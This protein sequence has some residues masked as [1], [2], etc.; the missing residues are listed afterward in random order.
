MV[1]AMAH[2]LGFF[3]K[4]IAFS[5][6]SR[7]NIPGD[8]CQYRWEQLGV[9]SVP[10]KSLMKSIVLPELPKVISENIV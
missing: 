3:F 9:A 8:G 6:V 10:K 2:I 1:Q 5:K 4:H 7:I